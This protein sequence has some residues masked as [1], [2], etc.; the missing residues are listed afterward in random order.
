MC[1]RDT[2]RR[3]V[4]YTHLDVYK[5]QALTVVTAAVVPTVRQPKQH[6]L[7]QRLRQPRPLLPHRHRQQKEDRLKC[8]SHVE[9]STVSS[10]TRVVPALL[11]AAPRS[12]SVSGV[13][14]P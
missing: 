7:L 4:S 14:R 2:W 5:R 8:L 1:I 13:S 11:R 9:S 10:T 3:P 6:L 12:P